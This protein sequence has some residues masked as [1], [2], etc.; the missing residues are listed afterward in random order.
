MLI[1]S[2]LQRHIDAICIMAQHEGLT[3]ACLARLEQAER[4]VPK[5]Q[6]TIEFVSKYLRQQVS[7]L[8]LPQ[9]ASS[10]MHAHL[11]PAYYLDRVAA[12]K[13]I[14]LCGLDRPKKAVLFDRSAE[15]FPHTFGRNDCSGAVLRSATTVDVCGNLRIG[16]DSACSPQS[17]PTS[18]GVGQRVHGGRCHD[19]GLTI[20]DRSPR[21][22][23]GNGR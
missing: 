17:T 9:P 12:T 22:R 16:R 14:H 11:I 15:L 23:G 6:A 5:M 13:L 2:D 19:R 21:F 7:Q 10:A 20:G 1:A 18:R 8:N 3:Q 4:V